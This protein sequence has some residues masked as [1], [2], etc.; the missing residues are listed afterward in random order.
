MKTLSFKDIPGSGKL[1]LDYM[2]Q[3]SNV[4]SL[5][6]VSP[7]DAAAQE[8]L[9]SRL[10]SKKTDRKQVS[11]ILARQNQTFGAS[12]LTL[13]NIKKLENPNTVA[14]VTGQQMGLFTGPLYT[15]YKSIGT[16]KLCEVYQK[17]FPQYEFVPVFWMELEDH[18]FD[19][20]RHVQLLSV[21]NDLKKISY[22]GNDPG[23]VIRNP[24]NQL[25]ITEDISRVL[26]EVKSV[27]YT[28]DFTHE[29]L[30]L[31]AK[32]YQ[33]T[34]LSQAFGKMLTDLLGPYGLIMM[35]PSDIEFK[36]I[37]APVFR[38][39]IEHTDRIHQ[40]LQTQS[41]TLKQS[42][43]EAQVET[44]PSNLF[45]LDN[46][47]EKLAINVEKKNKFR[48]SAGDIASEKNAISKILESSP[49]RFI[50]NVV[51]RP[52]VQD[53]LLPTFA[54]V[55]GP[56]EVAY[57]GQFKS[58]YE[59]FEIPQPMI[60]PRPFVTILEKKNAKVLDKYTIELLQVFTHSKT[61]VD[62]V[63]MQQSGVPIEAVFGQFVGQ[64]N[65]QFKAL[66]KQLTAIDPNLKG[67]L[68]T[69][70]QKADQALQVLKTKTIESEK[71]RNEVLVDQIRKLI[72][73]LYPHHN[74]QERELN[75][76][77]YLNKYGRDFIKLLHERLDV[78]TKDH[79]VIEL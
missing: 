16:I 50:P 58:V 61:L 79:Q 42:G 5:Y 75:A 3:F 52:I 64:M 54:Y 2:Y 74:F 60:V 9:L 70:Q 21:D 49:E 66:Q 44:A 48:L 31:I 57:F 4:Q 19:E 51:L 78:T 30:G 6:S 37:V 22:N 33:G 32:A 68:E 15:I 12:D 29:W 11:Q 69:A 46:G 72:H 77:Y 47:P 36:K 56:A 34:S 45:M 53:T 20:I 41:E 43:Y 26:D 39:E 28:T 8:T 17:K 59:F 55:A 76:L 63:T 1:F 71:R 40:L 35:D 38:K 24:V 25:P 23:N 27:L 67:A 62:Q 10:A 73:H 18:D 7:D 13:E 14:V 65:N